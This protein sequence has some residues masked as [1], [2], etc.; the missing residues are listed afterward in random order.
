[1]DVA[2]GRARYVDI[3]RREVDAL[4]SDRAA[5]EEASDHYRFSR[6]V[7]CSFLRTATYG[8]VAGSQGPSE[9]YCAYPSGIFAPGRDPN[10]QMRRYRAAKA[11][12]R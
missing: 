6:R 4:Y 10:G 5:L 12:P 1:M 2:A 9:I 11:T 3:S 7:F 8:G